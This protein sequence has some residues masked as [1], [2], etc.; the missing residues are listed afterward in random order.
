MEHESKK[1]PGI[2]CQTFTL[3]ARS[4]SVRSHA[5][6]S[7]ATGSSVRNGGALSFFPGVSMHRQWLKLW[8]KAEDSAVFTDSPAFHIFIYLLLQAQYRKERYSCMFE[9]HQIYLERG[10]CVIGRYKVAKATGIAPSTVRN[11]LQRLEKC[12]HIISTKT[13]NKRTIVSLLNWD[14]YQNTE[15]KEDNGRTSSGQ[16]VD[17]KQ[18]GKKVKKVISNNSAFESF[19]SKYPK[20]RNKGQAEVVWSKLRPSNDLVKLIEAGLLRAKYSEDWI[21]DDGK[22]IPYPSTWLRAKG[23]E[24]EY[25][26]KKDGWDRS[27]PVRN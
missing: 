7:Q 5:L 17:T 10:E 18:E 11:A 19:W 27:F 8:R 24:D 14:T 26:L 3:K 13:D 1:E 25:E 15:L 23:W 6:G 20:K 22:Y 21:K 16:Q 12:Y 4:T 2:K 9:G